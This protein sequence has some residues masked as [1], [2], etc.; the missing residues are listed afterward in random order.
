MDIFLG[1]DS[2]RHFVCFCLIF[3]GKVNVF[4]KTV[5]PIYI[6]SNSRRV[7]KFLPILDYIRIHSFSVF[8]GHKIFPYKEV[9]KRWHAWL[10][11]PDNIRQW[12]VKPKQKKIAAQSQKLQTVWKFFVVWDIWY[13][14]DLTLD[15]E[16]SSFHSFST[17]FKTF[18]MSL[19]ICSHSLWN[20]SYV[21]HIYVFM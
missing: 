18:R 20:A 11:S 12:E 19:S 4:S 13:L 16:D 10:S 21:V 15:C 2:T 14:K 1:I 8:Q 6:Q 7:W 5:A 17:I 3:L 9:L